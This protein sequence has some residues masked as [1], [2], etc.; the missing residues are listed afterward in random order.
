MHLLV[1]GKGTVGGQLLAQIAAE[2]VTLRARHDLDLRLAGVVDSGAACFDEAGLDPRDIRDQLRA[3]TLAR[4][5]PALL[6][7]LQRLSVPVLVDCTA[8]DGMEAIYEAAFARGIHVVTSNKKP[9]TIGGAARDALFAHARRAHRSLRYETTV[10]ASLPVID[11]L[12]NL[13]RTGDRVARIEA[14]LSGTLGYLAN[15]VTRGVRLSA[16]VRTA[17]DRGY[18]EPHPR[19]DLSGMDAARKALILARELGW[20]LEL[21]DVEVEPF[22][23][24]HLLAHDDVGTFLRALAAEDDAFERRLA[25]VRGEGRVLRYLATIAAVEASEAREASEAK[26]A[27]GAREAH[28]TMRATVRV[29]PVAVGAEHP[30]AR[31]RA[32]EAQVAF[33]TERY[34]EAPLVVQGAGA[35]GAITAAG[36]LADVLAIGHARRR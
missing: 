8:A 1:L 25:G 32:T 13:V 21:A 23:P 28:A 33:R 20:S 35:G 17:R 7:R 36:V 15:E 18:T 34:F 22:V 24:R 4:D 12:Q 6:D 3:S 2:R 26:E 10:G 27:S 16:A 29:A 5:V 11:T 30:A 19:D 9:L 31:L 14:S